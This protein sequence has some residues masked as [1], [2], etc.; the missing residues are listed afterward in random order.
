MPSLHDIE[1]AMSTLWMNRHA[2]GWLLSDDDDDQ[3]VIPREVSNIDQQILAQLDHKGASLYARTI[4]YE[5]QDMADCIFPNCAK[6]VGS[7]WERLVEDYYERYP[8]SHFNFNKICE[9]FPR[10]LSE[11]CPDLMG[12]Y[13]YLAELADYEWLELEKVEDARTIE[14]AAHVSITG[15]EQVSLY[16]PLVNQT[17]SVRHY[18][19]PV[20]DIAEKLEKS[21]RPR[22]HFAEK[23]TIVAIYRD[24]ETFRSRFIELGEAAGAIVETAQQSPTVY[25]D[26]LK[27]ALSLTEEINPANAAVEFLELIEELH[28]DNIFVGSI[29]KEDSNVGQ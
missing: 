10:F 6:V 20:P 16:Y 13:P 26:L 21:K 23:P 12:K 19:Y 25:Q 24:P 8:S 11:Q 5:H 9:N 1:K 29:R 18:A 7:K 17:L 14:K 27:L 3:K 2:R 28:T 22:K 4:N 15:L